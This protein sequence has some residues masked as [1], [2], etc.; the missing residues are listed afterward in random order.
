MFI[1]PELA[2]QKVIQ[3]GLKELREDTAPLD[4][5][6]AQ[7]TQDELSDEFDN[8]YVG[9]IIKW[10]L[11][12]KIPVVQAW[13]FNVQRIPCISIKLASEQEDEGK[14]ALGDI[15]IETDDYTGGTSPMTITVD[16]G[17]HTTKTGDH[18]LWL[19]YIV[20]YVLYKKKVDLERYGL[21]M[22]S[23]SASDYSK[24]QQK[25]PDNTW[26]RWIRYRCTTMNSFVFEYK[27]VVEKINTYP[28]VG[29]PEASDLA[30]GDDVD[31]STVCTTANKGILVSS[32]DDTEEDLVL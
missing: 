18:V 28:A 10:F 5:M 6:F 32:S 20:M 27:Q 15:S 2:I 23:F 13:S 8:E 17:I 26:T 11:D 24:D 3:Q 1:M 29:L 16:I 7:H 21:L 25:M 9:K 4:I 31:I 12:T 30:I 14:V 19:Y 22:Q